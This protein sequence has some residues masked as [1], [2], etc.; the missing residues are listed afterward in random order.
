MILSAGWCLSV[1]G[2]LRHQWE[3]FHKSSCNSIVHCCFFP[4]FKWGRLLPH[5]ANMGV[6]GGGAELV[7]QSTTLFRGLLMPG[8]WWQTCSEAV[9]NLKFLGKLSSVHAALVSYLAARFHSCAVTV[10]AAAWQAAAATRWGSWGREE[11]RRRGG[12]GGEMA[13]AGSVYSPGSCG[14]APRI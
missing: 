5:C 7:K 12:G 3:A 9:K 4:W 11:E 8:S 1:F 14:N 13:S 6:G 2:T 10:Q